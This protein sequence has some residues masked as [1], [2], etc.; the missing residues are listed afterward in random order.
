MY[1]F[2]DQRTAE[3]AYTF[4]VNWFESKKPNDQAAHAHSRDDDAA[5]A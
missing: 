3:D 5:K 2:G 4:L 1:T